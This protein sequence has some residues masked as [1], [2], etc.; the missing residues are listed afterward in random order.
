[1]CTPTVCSTISLKC[2]PRWAE[3]RGFPFWNHSAFSM[4]GLLEAPDDMRDNLED[5]INGLPFALNA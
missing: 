5:L 4:K 3:V 2:R 1:M